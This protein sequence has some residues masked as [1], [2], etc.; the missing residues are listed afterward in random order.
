MNMLFASN[1][2][3]GKFLGSVQESL[4]NWGSIIVS[5]IGVA[6][7]IV[8]IYKIA[9]NLISHGKGQNSWVIAIALV[10]VGGALAVAGG[11]ST[12]GNLVGVSNE[13]LNNFAAGTGDTGTT[14]KDPF[15][16]GKQVTQ[17][18]AAGT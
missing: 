5:I 12:L 17:Y 4:G 2:G 9:K 14:A 8:G 6:M 7:V 11:W 1:A 16:S 18:G 15:E 10:L 3:I 13:T